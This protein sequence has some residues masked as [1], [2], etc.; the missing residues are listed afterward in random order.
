MYLPKACKEFSVG[1]R[2]GWTLFLLA[3]R[4]LLVR[5]PGQT[6]LPPSEWH[7]YC[8]PC[9]QSPAPGAS[10][11]AGRTPSRSMLHSLSFA[12]PVGFGVL[13]R[14]GCATPLPS[15]LAVEGIRAYTQ[16]LDPFSAK[17]VFLAAQF[18]RTSSLSGGT[19]CPHAGALHNLTYGSDGLSRHA[20]P[21]ALDDFSMPGQQA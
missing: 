6:S 21:R 1:A 13:R 8:Q 18:A 10:G 14:G 16:E 3:P 4:M 12:L 17:H 11:G 15:P 2:D 7:E 20:D 19:A 5:A 9:G